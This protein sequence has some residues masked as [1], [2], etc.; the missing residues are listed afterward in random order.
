[1]TNPIPEYTPPADGSADPDPFAEW[2][3]D[4]GMAAAATSRQIAIAADALKALVEPDVVEAHG[5]GV[6]AKRNKAGAISVSIVKEA[7]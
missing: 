7:K 4:F 6:Q 1:M 3:Q 2:E 5:H